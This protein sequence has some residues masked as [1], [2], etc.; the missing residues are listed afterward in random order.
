MQLPG[1]GMGVING[2]LPIILHDEGKFPNE[3]LKVV[4]GYGGILYTGY[5]FAIAHDISQ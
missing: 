5:G 1:P 2:V 3:V 4:E